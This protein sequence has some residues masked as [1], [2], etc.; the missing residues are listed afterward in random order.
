M[1]KI[2]SSATLLGRPVQ[3]LVPPKLVSQ[4]HG[5][6]SIHVGMYVVV[7]DER[8][9][10]RMDRLGPDDGKAKVTLITTQG[11]Q[12]NISEHTILSTSK[13]MGCSSRRQHHG[14]HLLA[15]NRKVWLQ[16]TRTY[17]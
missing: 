17:K 16:F 12:N 15:E 13:K 6:N 7:V 10:R 9:Q 4:S 2:H 5:G 14:P 8:G 3:L 1:L 11:V